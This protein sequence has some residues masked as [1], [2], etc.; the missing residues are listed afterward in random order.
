M[1]LLPRY[2]LA[3][4]YG[5]VRGMAITSTEKPGLRL[6]ILALPS[7]TM[8]LF[9]IVIAVMLAAISASGLPGSPMRAAPPLGLI[10]AILALRDFLMQPEREKRTHDLRPPRKDTHPRLLAAVSDRGRHLGL[11]HPP[12]LMFA[13]KTPGALF[14][15]GSFRRRYLAIGEKMAAQ[16]EHDLGS[17]SPEIREQAEAAIVHELQHF[18]QGDVVIA[19]LTRSLLKVGVLLMLWSAAFFLGLVTVAFAF[20]PSGMFRPEFASQIGQINPQLGFVIT[21]LFTPELAEQVKQAP[22]WGLG[23]LYVLNAHLPILASGAVLFALVWRRLLTVRELYADAATAAAQGQSTGIQLALLR[24]GT[25][26]RLR[27]ASRLPASAKRAGLWSRRVLTPG[28]TQLTRGWRARVVAVMDSHPSLKVRQRG[29][30]NPVRVFSDPVWVGVTAGALVLLLDLLLIGPFTLVYVSGA[31]G[32]VVVLVGFAVIS[33]G[34]LP[35]LVADGRQAGRWTKAML[36]GVGLVLLIRMG[37][38]FLNLGL[39]WG[40]VLLSPHLSAQVLNE[41]AL[42][43]V[44]VLRGS[45]QVIR[46]NDLVGLASAGTVFAIYL[47]I[48]IAISLIAS[49]LLDY[50]L[51]RLTLTWY[52]LPDAQHRLI[53]VWWLVSAGIALGVGGV[54]LPVV[55]AAIPMTA[56]GLSPAKAALNGVSLALLASG[57]L[58]W[59]RLH[60]R[61]GRRC[62][63]CGE[64]VPGWFYLGRRCEA[65]GQALHHWLHAQY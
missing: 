30:E 49:L 35:L 29:L 6:R 18:S 59:R 3:C 60:R 4:R 46:V 12:R 36:L 27:P 11:D 62:P 25:T 45:V 55:S 52:G 42:T 54:W 37:F 23:G 41:V 2:T 44:G 58:W 39:L 40:G 31:P 14:A 28:I 64:S 43:S 50:H 20:P 34:L 7:Q 16:L 56:G 65:C 9:V 22:T 32:T 26:A 48:L 57:A 10:L 21:R 15:F 51:K 1:I 24:Y 19:G 61:Y 17:P 63:Q 5:R 13:H 8:L 47:T 33:L 53:R 38:H